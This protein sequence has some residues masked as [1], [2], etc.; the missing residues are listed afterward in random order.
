MGTFSGKAMVYSATG[1]LA[2]NPSD[3]VVEISIP[4]FAS[5]FKSTIEERIRETLARLLA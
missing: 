2:V 5:P 3:V 4:V 1:T